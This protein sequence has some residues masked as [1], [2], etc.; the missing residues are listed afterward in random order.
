MY[1]IAPEVEAFMTAFEG[2]AREFGLT[3]SRPKL[4]PV[5]V[6][7]D[8]EPFQV[9]SGWSINGQELRLHFLPPDRIQV[10]KSILVPKLPARTFRVRGSK[11]WGHLIDHLMVFLQMAKEKEEAEEAQRQ[12]L[13][14]N[15]REAQRILDQY[16]AAKPFITV[17]GEGIHFKI[18]TDTTLAHAL[19]AVTDGYLSKK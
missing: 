7:D 4:V 16:P 15:Q 12:H 8:G 13:R 18:T 5:R 1:A 11:S 3:V 10:E 2:R 9:L 6:N 17:T 19:A 14:H